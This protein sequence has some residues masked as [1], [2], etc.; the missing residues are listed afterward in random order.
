[1]KEGFLSNLGLALVFSAFSAACVNAQMPVQLSVDEIVERA[2]NQSNV[3][4]ETFKNLLSEE[5]KTFEIFDKKGGVKK[6]RTV[7]STFI[8]YQLLKDEGQIAE[9]RNVISVDEKRLENTDERA[10]D[11][12]EKVVASA[13]SQAELDRI[14]DESSRFDED[15]AISGLTLFQAIPFSGSLRKSF[16]FV[17]LGKES[18]P[19]GDV[20][21]VGYHQIGTNPAITISSSRTTNASHNYDIEIDDDEVELNP[22]VRGQLWIDAST[23]NVRREIRNRTIQPAGYE[24]PMVVAENS[25]EYA[26]SNFGVLLP[27]KI[28]H[29]QYRVRLEDREALKDTRVEFEYGNFTKP[30][31][32]VKSAEVK[33]KKP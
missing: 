30:D 31:V 6:R 15:F 18:G 11:F 4:V 19:S 29:L 28:T 21:V 3:Y 14:R 16:K 24:K 2:A 32:E 13:S 20:F 12:F 25:F 5:K 10:K 33:D 1:M 22:R 23:F 17:L 26:E 7:R 9:F 8:V 27:R